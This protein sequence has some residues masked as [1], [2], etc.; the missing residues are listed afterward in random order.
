MQSTP[1]TNL[2]LELLRVFAREVS[3]ND[4]RAIRKLLTDYFSEKAMNLADEA[5]DKNGWTAEDTEQLASGHLRK[6]S[7]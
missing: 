2:Q 1:L 7:I 5:W 4:V 6:S 3:D